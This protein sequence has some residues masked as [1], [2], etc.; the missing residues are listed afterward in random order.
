[1]VI[2]D[3]TVITKNFADIRPGTVFKREYEE[4]SRPTYAI[5][6]VECSDRKSTNI[7]NAIDLEDGEWCY[8]DGYEQVIPYDATLELQQ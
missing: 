1:M 2:I 7:I 3:N 5:K 4:G 8:F 6:I